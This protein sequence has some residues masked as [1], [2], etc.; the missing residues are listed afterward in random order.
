LTPRS[1]APSA[2]PNGTRYKSQAR[3][4]RHYKSQA[5]RHRRYKSQGRD[6]S[7]LR[8]TTQVHNVGSVPRN[9]NGCMM[10]KTLL[11]RL[12]GAQLVFLVPED[13]A[14]GSQGMSK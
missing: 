2:T 1:L 12:A 9:E 8:S 13:V 10:F 6:A 11:S 5:R 7:G 14:R 3:R 4:H